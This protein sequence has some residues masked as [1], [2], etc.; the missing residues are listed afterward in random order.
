MVG[1][2]E[3]AGPGWARVM[4]PALIGAAAVL[5]ASAV[6]F[7]GSTRAVSP[8]PGAAAGPCEL[9][10]S[11]TAVRQHDQAVTFPEVSYTVDG[12]GGR[13]RI[14]LAGTY[15]GVIGEGM[16]VVVVA[17]ADPRSRDSTPERRPG[18]GRFYYQREL[19]VD[20]E[21]R[22]WS[23]LS[24]APGYPGSSGL[25]WHLYLALVPAD[26]PVTSVSARNQVLDGVFA[27]LQIL[28]I[29]TVPT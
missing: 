6:G 7:S 1:S 22:C 12:T 26:F 9:L 5:I 15:Q 19:R 24:L 3:G 28:A 4:V 27:H 29:L 14:D 20:V 18:D 2:G 25:V 16:R 17:Q 23:A 13:P 8:S 11:R 10:A 21:T